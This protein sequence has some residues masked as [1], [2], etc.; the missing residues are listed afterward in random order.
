MNEL[1]YKQNTLASELSITPAALNKII[2]GKSK[3]SL[4]TILELCKVCEKNNISI[5]WLMLGHEQILTIP[6]KEETELLNEY[7][8][9]TAETQASARLLLRA[10]RREAEISSTYKTG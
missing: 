7:R 4:D 1:G 8:H 2:S 6:S 3:P 5:E 10:G 9:A